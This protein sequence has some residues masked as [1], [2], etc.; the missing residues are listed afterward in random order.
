MTTD[1]GTGHTATTPLWIATR[2]ILH[3]RGTELFTCWRNVLKTRDPEDIHDLRVASRRLREGL[4][5]FSPCYPAR[6]IEAIDKRV[7]KL[8]RLL[9]DMRNTDE[10]IVFFTALA[11]EVNSP[12]CCD[13]LLAFVDETQGKRKRETRRMVS[14]L[15]KMDRKGLF[16]RYQRVINKLSLFSPSDRGVDLLAPL[17][18]FAAA[19][20]DS[21]FAA[22]VELLGPAGEQDAIEAQHR[23][24][25]AIK[26][27]RYR[28][29]LLSFLFGDCYARL[30]GIVKNYQDV[31]G[32][33]NDLDVFG[34]MVRDGGF[35]TDVERELLECIATK[36]QE[37]FR[38]L[39]ALME[40][41]PLEMLGEKVRECCEA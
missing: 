29:E 2:I 7:K 27:F 14:G 8:T 31:L 13:E 12:A 17:S 20:F 6:T 40:D 25:I 37:R 16:T 32:T 34:Q 38:A 41:S 26:H 3:E 24:R 30:H 21:R 35:T 11:E 33:M 22:L 5:L 36:R 19:A 4:T 10:A 18:G 9:G 15:R 1:P 39:R 23:L 28:M